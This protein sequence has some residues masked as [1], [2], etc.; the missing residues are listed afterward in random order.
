MAAQLPAKSVLPEGTFEH[1]PAEPE[2]LQARHV[3]VQSVS[4]QTPSM[5]KVLAQSAAVV[6]EPPKP[7]VPQ[8]PS[9]HVL[10]ATHSAFPW[11][12]SMQE[13]PAALHV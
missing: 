4:Q 8:R 13:V 7:L 10:P 1:V 3:P 11:H 2:R 5:Q 12:E 6:H 9:T